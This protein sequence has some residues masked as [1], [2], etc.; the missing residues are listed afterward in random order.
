MLQYS[1]VQFIALF[2]NDEMSYLI[3]PD[4]S[5]GFLHGSNSLLFGYYNLLN[6]IADY[7]F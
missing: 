2:N 3:L 1:I 5:A 6:I 4:T 7:L